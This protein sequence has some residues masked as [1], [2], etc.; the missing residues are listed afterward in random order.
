MN[1]SITSTTVSNNN[2]EPN[3][4]KHRKKNSSTS[5]EN[6]KKQ[7]K[8]YIEEKDQKVMNLRKAQKMNLLLKNK[9]NFISSNKKNKEDKNV[10]VSSGWNHSSNYRLTKTLNNE[11]ILYKKNFSKCTPVRDSI[12]KEY[13]KMKGV[14]KKIN[15]K[16]FQ[17]VLQKLQQKILIYNQKIQFFY[18]KD[19]VV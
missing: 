15:L 17:N 5:S 4:K 16:K 2:T 18:M 9:L 11:N 8:I 7:K 19:I 12:L 6:H 10:L 13:K 14:K 3:R 1:H